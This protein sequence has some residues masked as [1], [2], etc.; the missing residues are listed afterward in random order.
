MGWYGACHINRRPSSLVGFFFFLF[1][2]AHIQLEET[3]RGGREKSCTSFD[4]VC[5]I[6]FRII[7]LFLLDSM[8]TIVP[9]R[10]KRASRA[11]CRRCANGAFFDDWDLTCH[12]PPHPTTTSSSFIWYNISHFLRFGP[13]FFLGSLMSFTVHLFRCSESP[14][15]DDQDNS[16]F[17]FLSFS[18]IPKIWICVVVVGGFFKL[19]KKKCGDGKRVTT[20]IDR[21]SPWRGNCRS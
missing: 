17:D 3:E 8:R 12:S 5:F 13:S 4:V 2:I 20:R 18:S 15:H 21:V 19:I 10:S 9:F 6:S 7:L 14:R 1:S 16:I 11:T